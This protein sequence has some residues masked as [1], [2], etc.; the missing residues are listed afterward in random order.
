MA[1]IN[2]KTRVKHPAFWIGMAGVVLSPILAYNGMDYS[3]LTSW[4]S[5]GDLAIGFIKNPYL[6]GS[7]VMAVLGALGVAADPNTAGLG[8]SNLAMSYE[9]PRSDKADDE[10][11]CT[12]GGTDE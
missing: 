7:T 1:S 9:R 10:A 12:I 11:N 5:V 3:S 2:W 6:I 4:Q 8:D